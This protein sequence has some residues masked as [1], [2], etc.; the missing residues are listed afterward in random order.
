MNLRTQLMTKMTFYETVIKSML[1]I[2][3]DNSFYSLDS[4]WTEPI[5]I[6]NSSTHF[7]AKN[8]KEILPTRWS[9]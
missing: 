8:W 9:L 2:T 4:A 3:S 7:K 1:F 6:I 5:K